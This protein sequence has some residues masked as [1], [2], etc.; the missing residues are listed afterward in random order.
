[1]HQPYYVSK[2]QCA[3]LRTQNQT[4]LHGGGAP[5]HLSHLRR[6][7]WRDAPLIPPVRILVTQSQFTLI[8]ADDYARVAKYTWTVIRSNHTMYAKANVDGRAIY[9]HRLIALGDN[10]R[11]DSLNVGHKNLL[12]TTGLRSSSHGRQAR[13]RYRVRRAVPSREQVGVV[14]V[15]AQDDFADAHG[16]RPAENRA[17]VNERMILAIFPARVDPGWQVTL[18]TRIDRTAGESCS[19]LRTVHA[20]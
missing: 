15:V 16:D 14:A 18:Q 9:M 1:M 8:D 12:V 6:R 4:R 10:S 11:M 20:G 7:K 2:G 3:P 13:A 17:V 19:H 5:K